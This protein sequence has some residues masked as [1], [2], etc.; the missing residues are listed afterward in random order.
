MSMVDADK[1]TDDR[2][3]PKLNTDDN[4]ANRMSHNTMG[5]SYRTTGLGVVPRMR[6]L[7]GLIVTYD[8][9]NRVSSVY[10]YIPEL[11]SIPVL[12]TAKTGY[13]VFTDILGIS[14]PST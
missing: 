13:D 8:A 12:I 7:N 5:N 3:N 9:S 14:T 1:A 4:V 10:G 11:S 6:F 2:A